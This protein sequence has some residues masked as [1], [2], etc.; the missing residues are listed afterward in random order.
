M[1]KWGRASPV[2][3]LALPIPPNDSL[4]LLVTT[5]SSSFHPPYSKNKKDILSQFVNTTNAA[6]IVS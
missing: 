5:P 6:P 2:L 3:E 4:Y 1:E